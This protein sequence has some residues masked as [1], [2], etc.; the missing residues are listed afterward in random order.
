MIITKE[1]FE[2]DILD[3]SDFIGLKKSYE[4]FIE[5]KTPGLPRLAEMIVYELFIYGFNIK[6]CPD[7]VRHSY[8]NVHEY[9]VE[10]RTLGYVTFK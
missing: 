10:L 8:R 9:S 2:H 7:T 6:D 5:T 3:L 1:Q 4:V